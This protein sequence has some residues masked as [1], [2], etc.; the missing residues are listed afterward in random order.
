MRKKSIISIRCLVMLIM[1]A[2]LVGT[3][4]AQEQVLMETRG[5]QGEE[6]TWY[7]DVTLTPEE[8]QKV[9]EGNYKAAYLMHTSSDFANALMAGAKDLFNELGIELVVTTD[10]AMDPTKQKTDV[11]TALA[12]L[13]LF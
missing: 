5:P 6:P 7:S 10:A 4:V 2:L 13:T 12:R 8:I 3:A 11:E 9:K 1:L